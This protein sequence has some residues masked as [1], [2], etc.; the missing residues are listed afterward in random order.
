[1]SEAP[2]HRLALRRALA[3][4]LATWLSLS[5]ASLLVS[6]GVPSLPGL[7]F[8]LLCGV[9]VAGPLGYLEARWQERPG[10]GV[11]GLVWLALLPSPLLVLV[12]LQLRY[13]DRLQTSPGPGQ[14]LESLLL[15]LDQRPIPL[16]LPAILLGIGVAVAT[17][18][19]A[20]AGALS[21]TGGALFWLGVIPCG[22]GLPVFVLW[23][24]IELLCGFGDLLERGWVWLIAERGALD[25]LTPARVWLLAY[26]G[27]PEAQ[28]L[29]GGRAP[30]PPDELHA[31][32]IGLEPA[33]Q[34]ALS[35]AA[36][37]TLRRVVR[38]STPPPP[39]WEESFRAWR[40][41]SDEPSDERAHAVRSALRLAPPAEAPRER[42]LRRLGEVLE[43][44][45]FTRA[46]ALA[47]AL[48]RLGEAEQVRL[49]VTA[50]LREWALEPLQSRERPTGS[51]PLPRN[52][53]LGTA[54]PGG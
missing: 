9:V 38:E 44:G 40:A 20:A 52:P 3:R 39:G 42:A 35:R 22:A 53:N 13:L 8:A 43:P 41:W 1:M 21:M 31:W 49:E 18:R 4:A 6:R 51:P 50:E 7:A 29:L 46:A 47:W 5:A 54:G 15:E 45:V 11:R 19:C 37:A 14:A 26:L 10:Q 25:G 24:G 23:V 28:R 27:E 32:L 48:P 17:C 16:V 33:G 30:L 34:E 12:L 2:S 36:E